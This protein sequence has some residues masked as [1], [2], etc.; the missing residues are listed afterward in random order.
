VQQTLQALT[1]DTYTLGQAALKFTTAHQAVSTVAVGASKKPQIVEAAQA[2]EL[3]DLTD[4]EMESL[5]KA[6]TPFF[7]QKHR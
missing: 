3:S 6:A 5:R 7:Y 1:H 4:I 2:S